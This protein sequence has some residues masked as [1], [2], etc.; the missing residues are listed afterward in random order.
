MKPDSRKKILVALSGGVDSSTAAA[1]LKE[2]N[3]EVAAAI[4]I[5]QGVAEDAIEHAHH[6]A[7]HLDI[8][9]H[10]FDFTKQYKDIIVDNFINEYKSGRTPNPCVLCNKHIKFD[11]FLK[12]AGDMGMDNIATGHYAG[13]EKQNGRYLLKRG[14]DRNEQSYFLY[15]LDQRQLAQIILPLAKYTKEEIRKLA[16]RFQLPTADRK[17]SQDVC[18]IPDGDYVTYLKNVLHPIPGPI[19]DKN[20]TVIGEHKG[21]LFYTYGQRQGIGI[22][23]KEPYYVIKI[24][25]AKNAIV[26]GTKRD[27]YKNQALVAD[28]N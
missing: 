5:F 3:F 21:I 23:H 11:L 28:L 19:L 7:R 20:G 26:V 4:M 9:F 14:I 25:S 8:P 1:L 6:T 22:S 27:V 10:L 13:L 17:K 18:F 2:Q 12:M 15:R 16:K 24:D